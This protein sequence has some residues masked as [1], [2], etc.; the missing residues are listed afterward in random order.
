M[1]QHDEERAQERAAE[2]F[3]K[4]WDDFRT[5][6]WASKDIEEVAALIQA[7]QSELDAFGDQNGVAEF[8]INI[9]AKARSILN[10]GAV[11]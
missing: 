1:S 2:R 3:T 8:V 7:A 5:E 4:G 10:K 9:L 6:T 11:N